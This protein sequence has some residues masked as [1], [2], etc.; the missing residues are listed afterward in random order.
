MYIKRFKQKSILSEK[1]TRDKLARRSKK[2]I[3]T[4]KTTKFCKNCSIKQEPNYC[5]VLAESIDILY[6]NLNEYFEFRLFENIT[7]QYINDEW[8]MV[9]HSENSLKG[10]KV[11]KQCPKLR[12]LLNDYFAYRNNKIEAYE[13]FNK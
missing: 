11:L 7:K 3:K 6:Q 13:L 4:T 9:R 1:K 5:K 8:A 2:P 10:D 12:K